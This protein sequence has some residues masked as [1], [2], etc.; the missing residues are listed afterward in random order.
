MISFLAIG[1]FPHLAPVK[2]MFTFLQFFRDSQLD[3]CATHL[4]GTA[5]HVHFGGV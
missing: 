4:L 2:A 3:Y 5:A 1:F